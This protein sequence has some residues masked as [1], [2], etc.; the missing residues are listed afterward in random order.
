M[1]RGG[2]GGGRTE[3]S[4]IA[5]GK[6][7]GEAGPRGEYAMRLRGGLRGAVAGPGGVE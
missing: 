4:A 5:R 6:G 7:V 3:S 2:G 1:R